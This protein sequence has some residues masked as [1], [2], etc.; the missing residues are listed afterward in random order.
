[1]SAPDQPTSTSANVFAPAPVAK[2]IVT[3]VKEGQVLT[4]EQRDRIAA[5]LKANGINPKQVTQ[6]QITVTYGVYGSKAGRKSITFE[7]YYDEG[8]CRLFD[9]VTREAAKFQR[10][11]EQTV[12]LDPDPAWVGW[13]EHE[14]EMA[15]RRA[16][17]SGSDA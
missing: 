11:V 10:H 3:V 5:W 7:Q 8:G 13:D 1:M 15:V 16:E 9:P 4:D 14:K 2:Q 6:G 17:N 12:E